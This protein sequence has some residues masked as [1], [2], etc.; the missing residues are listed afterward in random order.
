[1]CVCGVKNPAGMIVDVG[2]DDEVDVWGSKICCM[3]VF[4]I[5]IKS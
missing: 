3:M 5:D 2:V 1:M 4:A